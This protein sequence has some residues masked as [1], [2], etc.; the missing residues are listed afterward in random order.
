MI[1]GNAF[2][3]WLSPSFLKN[4]EKGR[5][6]EHAS[7]KTG[8][9]T[10]DNDTFLRL[11]TE[12][13]A[14]KIGRKWFYLNKGG[15]FRKWYG[16]NEYVVNWENDGQAI[17]AAKGSTIRNPNYYF[18]EGITWS[19]I[20]SRFAGRYA[21]S[22]C[23]FDAVGLMCVPDKDASLNYLLGY[24]C[25]VVSEAYMD[26]LSPTLSYTTGAV[27][28]LPL[29]IDGDV[30]KKIDPLVQESVSLAETD[31]NNFEFAWGGGNIYIHLQRRF[32]WE[33]QS[34]LNS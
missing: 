15:E 6:G 31:W 9:T 1:P 29:I 8:F 7:P 12:I 24:F 22:K 25:S 30:E 33:L 23:L 16:D 4:F 19:K 11:W 34:N 13:D 27:A 20:C 14:T 10:G 21:S 3:Y 32:T 28:S 26:V 5:L 18:K 2:A 17:K